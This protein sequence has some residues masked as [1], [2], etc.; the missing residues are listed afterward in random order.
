MTSRLLPIFALALISALPAMLSAQETSAKEDERMAALVRDDGQWREPRTRVTVGVRFLSTGGQVNFGN[1][2]E[3]IP[4][5][6]AAVSAGAADRIY[7]NGA[8]ALD[9]LRANEKDANGNQVPL[10]DGRYTVTNTDGQVV[11]NLLGYQAGATR[12]WQGDYAEQTAAQAGYVGF[13]SYTAISEGGAFTKK[14]GMTGG[15]ELQM[16]RDLGRMGRR[17]HWGLGAGV[18]LNGINSKTAGT[19]SSTL[20]TRTDYYQILGS[21]TV[22]LPYSTPSFTT[23]LDDEGN[24]VNA[25]GLETTV[26]LNNT[27]DAT[28]STITDLAGGA[29]VR[30]NWQIKGAYL[31]VK[32]GP[33]LRTQLTERFGLTASAG[34]AGAYAG[35]RYSAIESFTVPDMS[36]L[37][38]TVEDI[39]GSTETKFL[40]GFYAD[41]T[42][43]WLA[44]DTAGLF[45]GVTAQQFGDYEQT[46]GS[47]TAKIDLGST[48]GIRGGV[49]IRF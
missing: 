40:S 5:E 49:S 35:T 20:R 30:G 3:R 45:G 1:L 12:N 18:T 25:S 10:T 11:Q 16:S 34:F 26:A 7:D 4:D 37:E 19:V 32:V 23:L 28:L 22:T 6:I 43:E 9:A 31:M 44:N 41:L 33:T 2:G 48:V 42:L 21:T 24:I 17:V 29:E 38:I 36:G 15:L 46:L 14:Q 47:R 39:D 8:V 27:P 13:S